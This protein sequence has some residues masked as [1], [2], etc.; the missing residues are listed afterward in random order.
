MFKTA[1]NLYVNI[2]E[3]FL[4]FS[5]KIDNGIFEIL[6]KIEKNYKN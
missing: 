6:K 2:K 5:E 4:R 1:Y 3:N